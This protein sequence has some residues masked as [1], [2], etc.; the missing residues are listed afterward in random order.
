MPE[1]EQASTKDEKK[2]KR[3]QIGFV[4]SNKM[5]KTIIVKSKHLV[6]H[7]RYRKYVNRTV[8]FY[9]HDENN[10][11]GI[12]DKVQIIESRPLSKQKRWRLVKILE[13]AE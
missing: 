4:T 12:G 8:T 2:I 10:E 9:A 1:T 6:K 3:T 5:H 13:K 11:A 7:Q